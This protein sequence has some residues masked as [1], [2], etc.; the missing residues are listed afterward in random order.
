MTSNTTGNQINDKVSVNC[1][2]SGYATDELNNCVKGFST[3]ETTKSPFWNNI[4]S[5]QRIEYTESPVGA[6]Q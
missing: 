3:Q 1:K 4:G 6:T 5:I 2:V